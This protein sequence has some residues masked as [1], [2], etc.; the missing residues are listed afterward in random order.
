M[1]EAQKHPFKVEAQRT[2]RQLRRRMSKANPEQLLVRHEMWI[3]RASAAPLDMDANDEALITTS[4]STSPHPT[5]VLVHYLGDDA[6][7]ML[8]VPPRPIL[9]KHPSDIAEGVS[10]APPGPCSAHAR[11][12]TDV[13]STNCSIGSVQLQLLCH[14][15]VTVPEEGAYEEMQQEEKE[16][17]AVADFY[18]PAI[19]FS[20]LSPDSGTSNTIN[21]LVPME[22]SPSPVLHPVLARV[23][24]AASAKPGDGLV[25]PAAALFQQPTQEQRSFEELL[26][27]ATPPASGPGPSESSYG[28]DSPETESER[29]ANNVFSCEI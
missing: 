7:Q 1:N 4:G 21:H 16:E 13:V 5:L 20:L 3:Q 9:V 26:Q 14:T 10:S 23:V 22:R 2:N 11:T 19:D 12:G 8:T 29:F 18:S 24:V 28:Y 25:L 15:D 27:Y 6:F 17:A